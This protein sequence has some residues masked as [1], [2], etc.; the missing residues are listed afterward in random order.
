MQRAAAAAPQALWCL[1]A[2][3]PLA[4]VPSAPAEQTNP[5]GVCRR[6]FAQVFIFVWLGWALFGF[7]PL[8][9]VKVFPEE[10]PQPLLHPSLPLRCP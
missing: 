4:W 8:L 1:Q 9:D 3:G 7:K 5:R 6:G 10:L 2:A